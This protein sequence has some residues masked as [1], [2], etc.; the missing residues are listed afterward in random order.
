ME[1][2]TFQLWYATYVHFLEGYMGIKENVQTSTA[3]KI[4]IKQFFVCLH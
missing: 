1:K 2:Q 4:W 3:W